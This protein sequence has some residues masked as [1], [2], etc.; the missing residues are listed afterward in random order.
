V[1]SNQIHEVGRTGTGKSALSRRRLLKAGG[2]AA[3]L[4]GGVPGIT[5]PDRPQARQKTLRILR[6]KHFVPSFE[7]WFSETYIQEW[8]AQNDTQVIVDN[9]GTADIESHAEA[10]ADAQ[11]GHDLVFSLKPV[12][13]FEDQ[14]IDHREV[15]E[16]CERRHGRV[17][18]FATQSTYNPR[19]RKY[20]AFCGAYQAAVLTYR[21]DLWDAVAIAPDSWEDIL[22]GGR[23]IN[24]LHDSPAGFSLAPEDN[25]NWTMRAI[26]YGFGSSEQDVDGN[27]A[28]KSK[29]MLEAITYLK[30]LYEQAMAKD[31][32]TWD[33]TSNNRVM[34]DG[35][36][37]L[38]LDA[39]SIVR[40][41]ESLKLPVTRDLQLGK[42]PEGPA[43]RLGPAFGLVTSLIW[44]FSSNIDGAKQFLVD[45]IASSRQALIASGFQNMPSF[46]D[47][48]SDLA[49][50][51][52][53]D[54]AASPPDKYSLLPGGTSWT[55][56][57]GHP[58]YT[59]AAIGEIFHAGLIPTMFARAATGQLTPEEALD[60]ADG[61]VRVI[62]EK[63][64]ERGKV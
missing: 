28:L 62:F 18:E 27:P 22:A 31:V 30:A 9:V 47:A 50:L 40:A 1:S 33:H 49:T 53:N 59:N 56:N 39:L 7:E 23:R 10:E 15:Y 55:T 36:G 8:G 46:T 34:L 64:Q 63:W 29:A 25:S 45:Y 6:W 57:I 43:A 2:A 13:V 32:L 52:A 12:A 41:S 58:G 37:C 51:V 3:L 42:M 38:T 26:M 11:R 48:V 61:E 17:A 24:L 54:P 35:E 4:A 16:E 19:T 21:K 60:Q 44:K 20:F 14:V 5:L